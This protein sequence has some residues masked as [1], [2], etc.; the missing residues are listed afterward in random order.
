MGDKSPKSI[1]KKSSQKQ[2]KASGVADK[3]KAAVLTKQVAGKNR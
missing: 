2:V 3:K 1:Q